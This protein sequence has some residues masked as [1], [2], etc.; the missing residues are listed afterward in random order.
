VNGKQ[1]LVVFLGVAL[2]AWEFWRGWQR[3]T[4]FHGS[5]S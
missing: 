4:L 5:W 1:N 2:I 3:P